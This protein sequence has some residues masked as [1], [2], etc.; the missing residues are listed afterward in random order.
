LSVPVLHAQ[1]VE[2]P[3]G[4]GPDELLLQAE[5]QVT[6]TVTVEDLGDAEFTCLLACPSG[7]LQVGDADAFK[8]VDVPPGELRVQVRRQPRE[9]A[10]VVVLHVT[11][12]V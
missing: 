3:E 9:F 12:R 5:V 11:G 1:D 6:V 10:E 8:T 7:R 2:T 4:L